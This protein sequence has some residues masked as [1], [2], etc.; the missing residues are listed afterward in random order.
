MDLE[1]DL[2]FASAPSLASPKE[3]LC[4]NFTPAVARRLHD[5]G[6]RLP[7]GQ[8][9]RASGG[10]GLGFRDVCRGLSHAKAPAERRRM[11]ERDWMKTRGA[12]P[13]G[14]G[15]EERVGEEQADERVK[16]GAGGG[17]KRCAVTDRRVEKSKLTRRKIQAVPSFFGIRSVTRSAQRG[18]MS[19]NP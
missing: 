19:A 12:L 18:A 13:E 16:M 6:L 5:R 10:A 11:K 14:G 15:D 2:E 1:I 4:L 3:R 9:S 7:G 17:G 8:R